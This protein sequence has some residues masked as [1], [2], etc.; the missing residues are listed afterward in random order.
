MYLTLTGRVGLD[1]A[2]DSLI[3]G[4]IIQGRLLTYRC[5]HQL[6]GTQARASSTGLGL[7]DSNSHSIELGNSPEDRPARR[8]APVALAHRSFRIVRPSAQSSDCSRHHAASAR[9]M[10]AKSPENSSSAVRRYL[11]SPPAVRAAVVEH[12]A[13][14]LGRVGRAQHR[15]FVRGEL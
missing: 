6:L 7:V 14:Q 12:Q 8:P 15:F 11:M 3:D 4:R 10:I 2:S 13:Q 1:V 9:L 5:G